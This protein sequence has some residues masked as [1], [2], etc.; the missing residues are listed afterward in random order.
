MRFSIFCLYKDQLKKWVWQV[1]VFADGVGHWFFVVSIDWAQKVIYEQPLW[2]ALVVRL[3]FELV[4]SCTEG[5]EWTTTPLGHLLN[6]VTVTLLILIY[7]KNSHKKA[8]FF[9]SLFNRR[10]RICKFCV[11]SALFSRQNNT[12][13]LNCLI[14]LILIVITTPSL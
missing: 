6:W 9:T 4:T 14:N 12:F 8:C 1:P 3:G 2:V 10:H 7:H 13:L 11:S 5:R